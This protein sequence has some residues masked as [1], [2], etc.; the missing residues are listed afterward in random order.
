VRWCQSA[1]AHSVRILIRTPWFAP[2]QNGSACAG[3]TN[4]PRL[5]LRTML[6]AMKAIV[7][8]AL[9]RRPA[10]AVPCWT[11]NCLFGCCDSG[12]PP[13]TCVADGDPTCPAE[14]RNGGTG[15]VS[16]FGPITLGVR[17]T[18]S[19]QICLTGVQFYHEAGSEEFTTSLWNKTSEANLWTST[20][21]FTAGGWLSSSLTTPILMFPGNEFVAAYNTS[22]GAYAYEYYYFN[23]DR[24]VGPVTFGGGVNGVYKYGSGGLYPG[25]G[26]SKNSNYFVTPVWKPK[27]SYYVW[28]ATSDTESFEIYDGFSGCIPGNR[29]NIEARPNCQTPTTVAFKLKGVTVNFQKKWTE[30]EA[31][32][33]LWTNVGADVKP[34]YLL[35]LNGVYTLTV[36]TTATDAETFTFTQACAP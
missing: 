31:P 16:D 21:Y 14:C 1:R 11:P 24:T 10:G 36:N 7:L 13:P 6:V 5:N 35:L 26:P 20:S 15:C 23:R 19:K 17:F 2:L 29:Y 32:F 4:I 34:S 8:L 27:W 3:R 28:N 33:F 22:S 30:S 9:L 25:D 18:T 12:P